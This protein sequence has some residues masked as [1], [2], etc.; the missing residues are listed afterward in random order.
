MHITVV[1]N[2]SLSSDLSSLVNSSDVVVR[3]NWPATWGGDSGTRFDLWVIANGRAGRKFV[4][5]RPFRNS[6]FKHLPAQIW[7]PRALGMHRQLPLNPAYGGALAADPESVDV[8]KEILSANG[9][10]QPCLRFDE[11]F[12]SYCIRQLYGDDF[13]NQI[14][15]MPS[16]GFMATQYILQSMSYD[17]LTLVG[18]GFEGWPG[19]PWE[20]E[21]SKIMTLADQGALEFIAS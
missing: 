19:H 9:L 14:I 20:L 17:R 21:R 1:G 15:L 12:Y 8:G 10:R 18:F 6:A 11:K 13:S 7:F 3:F 4:S 16:S 2:A 5:Q